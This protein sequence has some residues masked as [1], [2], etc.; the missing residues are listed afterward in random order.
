MPYRCRSCK[1]FFSVKTNSL[2]HSSKLGC[3]TWVL[4][5]YLLITS[6]K[7][8][9]SKQ[10][11]KFLGVTQKTAWYLAHRIRETWTDSRRPLTG[12][13]EVDETYVG[14]KKRH[15]NAVRRAAVGRGPTAGKTIVVGMRERTTQ[16]VIALPVSNTTRETLHG[17]IADHT[18]ADALIYTDELPAYRGLPKHDVVNHR[19]REYVRGDV[20][21]NGIESFWAILKRGYMGTYHYMSPQH[22]HRYVNEFTGRY[23]SRDKNT[24]DQMAAIAKRMAGKRMRYDELVSEY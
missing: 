21:T 19:K 7:G 15:M 24:I 3:R 18:V 13:V 4:A 20:H 8:I 12:T 10:L 23:N 2:M 14:G 9:S 17:F 16:Q 6:P 5:V 11:S 22:L 1:T